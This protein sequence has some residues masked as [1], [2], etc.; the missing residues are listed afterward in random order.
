MNPNQFTMDNLFQA[1]QDTLA[2]LFR[3]GEVH[4]SQEELARRI[5]ARNAA[6]QK[7]S[8]KKPKKTKDYGDNPT[9][10]GEATLMK[11]PAKADPGFRQGADPM[12]APARVS[13]YMRAKLEA[14]NANNQRRDDYY[15]QRGMRLVP[16][17]GPMPEFQWQAAQEQ[18][19]ADSDRRA[20]ETQGIR[21]RMQREREE[22]G[23]QLAREEELLAL[24]RRDRMRREE[25]E[26]REEARLN[27]PAM[28][29]EEVVRRILSQ[30][31]DDVR[32]TERAEAEV[33]RQLRTREQQAVKDM[34]R[35]GDAQ[36]IP[37]PSRG[38]P[39]NVID[40]LEAADRVQLR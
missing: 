6:M 18:T 21:E 19:R 4:V 37:P 28:P 38:T 11:T 3:P 24:E 1:D 32:R 15:A 12:P 22:Y 8:A 10:T 9:A 33:R 35:M 26:M 16:G 30:Q 29:L 7:R 40:M 25:R 17:L 23:R 14:W 39:Y 13:P 5:A 20:M 2:A 27:Q 31:G 36:S 34:A